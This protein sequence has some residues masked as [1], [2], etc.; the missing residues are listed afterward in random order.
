MV[1]KKNS[2]L[3]MVFRANEKNTY[4]EVTIKKK[5]KKIEILV[6]INVSFE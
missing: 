2:R 4:K 6:K 1:V 5:E 3:N